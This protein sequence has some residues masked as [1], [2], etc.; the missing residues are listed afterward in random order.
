MSKEIPGFYYDKEKNRYFPIKGPIP[1]SKSIRMASSA[2]SSANP[3]PPASV[4]T[5]ADRYSNSSSVSK[6][7][8]ARELDG[9]T[10]HL[11][12]DRR[13]RCAF[14]AE[15]LSNLVSRPQVWKFEDID[16]NAECSLEIIPINMTT[17]KGV[18]RVHV[19]LAGSVHGLMSSF[20]IGKAGEHLTYGQKCVPSLVLPGN[21]NNNK[22]DK[23]P[24]QLWRLPETC[25]KLPSYVSCIKSPGKPYPVRGAFGYT[26]N[27]TMITTLGSGSS[28]GSV[29][30]LDSTRPFDSHSQG[31]YLQRII[32]LASLGCTIWTADCSSVDTRA[33]VGTN[34]GAALVD[35]RNGNVSWILRTGS[36]VLALQFDQSGNG[37]LCGLRNGVILNVDIREGHGASSMRLR[38]NLI[39]CSSPSLNVGSSSRRFFKIHGN[40]YS[41]CTVYMPKSVSSLLS[42]QLYDQYFLASS[43]D[44]CIKLFD[45][46]LVGRGPVQ[47]Y[48]GN[49]NTHL[50]LQLGVDPLEKFVVSGG[51]DYSLRIWCIT[52]G[53]LLFENKLFSSPPL[54]TRTQ[55]AEGS[56]EML[57]EGQTYIDYLRKQGDCWGSWHGS[58]LGLFYTQWC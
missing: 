27:Y 7:V 53:K 9:N 23:P 25:V 11:R 31:S 1:G 4:S 30:V 19:M 35:L 3:T 42:L 34:R 48:E 2:S 43:M 36:D 12:T 32:Y 54:T 39:P 51:D 13:P 44:G 6:L 41:S 16:S 49:L 18:T 14:E 50:R 47:S 45:Q 33:V 40:I 5:V 26:A 38:N 56:I 10:L 8:Q 28:G 37:L 22:S 29:Y 15:I 46:R 24:A 20:V 57:D 17:P 58:R 21:E 55:T 52:S